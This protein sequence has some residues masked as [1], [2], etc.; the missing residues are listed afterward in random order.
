MPVNRCLAGS[1]LRAVGDG[2]GAK[3]V[4]TSLEGLLGFGHFALLTKEEV[5]MLK[6]YGTAKYYSFCFILVKYS[7]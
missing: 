4:S 7:S 3:S 2:I 6:N 1:H 5:T